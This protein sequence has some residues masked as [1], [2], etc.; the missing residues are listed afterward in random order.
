MKK[1]LLHIFTLFS[2]IRKINLHNEIYFI[3]V[4]S[5]TI[6]YHLYPSDIDDGWI[7]SGLINVEDYSYEQIFQ[8]RTSYKINKEYVNFLSNNLDLYVKI[9]KIFG[10]Q[11]ENQNDNRD[12][13]IEDLNKIEKEFDIFLQKEYI[14]VDPINTEIY[15]MQK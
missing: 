10:Q 7:K 9:F 11:P 6:N 15:L 5:L 14:D 12:L 13:I 3:T 1:N 8:L 2:Y 4:L